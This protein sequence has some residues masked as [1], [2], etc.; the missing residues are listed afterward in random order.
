VCGADEG[1][2]VGNVSES[3]LVMV[4]VN[5]TD[6]PDPSS[7]HILGLESRRWACT[8]SRTMSRKTW[9]LRGSTIPGI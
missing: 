3:E 2:S 6:I 5:E 7:Y 1:A 8:K 4:A 9:V